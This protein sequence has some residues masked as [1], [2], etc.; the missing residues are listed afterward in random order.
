[1]PL[2][3]SAQVP[4]TAS[5]PAPALM[6]TGPPP[7]P[8]ETPGGLEAARE[9]FDRIRELSRSKDERIALAA[10]KEILDRVRGRPEQAHRLEAEGAGIVVVIREGRAGGRDNE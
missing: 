5:S 3:K 6:A 2:H 9:S 1:M 7:G 10:S 4:A 8:A